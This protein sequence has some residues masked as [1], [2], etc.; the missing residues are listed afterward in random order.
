M[1][2]LYYFIF[3]RLPSPELT[4]QTTLNFKL[5]AYT[6]RM[7]ELQ[8]VPPTFGSLI[9]KDQTQ[10]FEH[11]NKHSTNSLN[12]TPDLTVVSPFSPD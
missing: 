3:L 4:I 7:L 2:V 5:F 9:L 6:S 8:H 1:V 10:S 11:T 12:Y